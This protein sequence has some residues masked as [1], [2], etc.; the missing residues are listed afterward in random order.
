MKGFVSLGL[1]A[2]FL[3]AFPAH[4]QAQRLADV[5][6]SKS[7]ILADTPNRFGA[8]RVFTDGNGA[9]VEWE[10]D[11]ETDNA[12]FTVHRIDG[13]GAEVATSSMILG[14]S[15]SYGKKRVTGERYSFFD[16]NGGPGAVYYVQFFAMDGKTGFSGSTA[17]SYVA[18]LSMAGVR[19]S[20]TLREEVAE[21]KRKGIVDHER[22]EL[23]KPL[24]RE[25]ANNT[26]DAD[27]NA[28][29]W[30]VT[31]PGVRIGVRSE[32]FYRVTKAELQAAGFNV[33]SDPALWQLYRQGVQ[34]SILVGPNGDHI[35]FFARGVDTPETD[36]AVYFLVTGQSAGKRI[37]TKVA[38]PYAGSATSRSYSQVF[39]QKQRANYLNQIL[40]GDL[41]NYWG[42]VVSAG[43]NTTYNFNL[44]G[45]DFQT[46]QATL[47]L[48]FQ[49]YS[50][51]NHVINVTLNG[52]VLANVTGTSRTPFSKQYVIPTAFLREGA[53][54]IVFRAAASSGDFN[55]FDSI[56]VGFARKHIASSDRLRFYTEG[57]KL[58]K[59]T[60]FSTANVRVFDITSETD[61]ILWTNLDVIQ[62]GGTFS[63]R[64][65]ADRGRQMYAVG[66]PGLRQAASI[67]P[68]D[69]ALLKTT[70][71]S[72]DLV[73]IVHK[74]WLNEAQAWANYRIGQGFQV[75]IVEVSEIY[76]EF[77]YGDLSSI[78]M[79]DF[80]Q[81]AKNNW[82]TPPGYVLLLGDASYD[83]RNYQGL[84]YNNYVPTHIVNTIFTETGSDDF[85]ADFNGDGLAEMAIGRVPARTG[86]IITNALTKV[87]SWEQNIPTLQNRGALFAFDCFDA[88]NNYNFQEYSEDLRDQLPVGVS[89]TMAGKCDSAAPP[90]TPQSVLIN[91]MNTGKFFVNYSG[92][93]TTGAW[94]G[95][96]V[97]FSNN[98]VPQLTN[99]TNQSIY[100]MLTCLNGYFLHVA[101]KSLAENLL[102]LTTGGAVA[103]WAST[104]ETT[105]DIQ[106][107]MGA[108]FFNKLGSGSIERLGDLVNDAKTVI[109][110][111]TDVRLSWALIGDPMLKVHE[112]AAAAADRKVRK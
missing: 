84:G 45:V 35:D 66:D 54:S 106:N 48:K 7:P 6:T 75:K 3:C 17:A 87:M 76:D 79:R 34:Q 108:R 18:D 33:N 74:N 101:N 29:A 86:Q 4:S 57:F 59:L 98:E 38:R 99:Q 28:H 20:D 24:F 9:F 100:T 96:P 32:G 27:A 36:M 41:E 93:G 52:E 67:T 30:V 65:P 2:S 103:A 77:N 97:Y 102:D 25:V 83:S 42:A 44:T 80:L 73:I 110:T 64:M 82:Q 61:P 1:I 91:A 88:A 94:S 89:S 21:S 107:I 72:A 39:L 69:P 43:G 40:N 12:G 16:E 51:D 55:L 19:S 8:V 5:R 68:N 46:Q 26:P 23:P 50:F 63:V 10:M 53:N 60:D 112:P 56:S 105:P 90:A 81:Y 58:G 31:Q 78:S 15:A 11:A 71:H 70:S 92:H 13:A 95:S 47:E 85:L 111:G 104:G 109:P 49:G 14:S 62:E 22:L 37:A